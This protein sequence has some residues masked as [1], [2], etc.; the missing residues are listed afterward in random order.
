MKQII[1]VA[2]EVFP[3][4]RSHNEFAREVYHLKTTGLWPM[5]APWLLT[6]TQALGWAGYPWQETQK[7][8]TD[9]IKDY[10]VKKLAETY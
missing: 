7:I 9:Y 6:F 8:A 2:Q 5:H 10:G 4:D 1:E 3:D